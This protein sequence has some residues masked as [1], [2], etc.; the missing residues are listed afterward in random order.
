[1]K[2]SIFTATVLLIAGVTLFATATVFSQTLTNKGTLSL[3]AEIKTSIKDSVLAGKAPVLDTSKIT[4]DEFVK[5]Y[6]EVLT[7]LGGTTEVT[8]GDYNLYNRIRAKA[9]EKG[10][11][12]AP[13]KSTGLEKRVYPDIA[14]NNTQ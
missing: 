1:M 2:K 5:L 9:K 8:D 7:D 13:S 4:T 11:T 12:V 6:V 10:L 3:N 14:N